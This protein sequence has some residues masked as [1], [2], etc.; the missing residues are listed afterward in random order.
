MPTKALSAKR[1]E[2]DE[3]RIYLLELSELLLSWRWEGVVGY[4]AMV[5]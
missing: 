2:A 5:A 1:A 3:V 4:E